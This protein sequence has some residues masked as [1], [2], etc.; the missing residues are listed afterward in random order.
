VVDHEPAIRA[1]SARILIR[2]G[3]RVLLASDGAEAL[4]LIDRQG[5]PRLMLTGPV[6]GDITGAE[7]AR[8]VSADW[9]AVP[10]LLMSGAST[11]E[12]GGPA[13]S[14]PAS[15]HVQN[16]FPPELLVARVSEAIAAVERSE[17]QK[18]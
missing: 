6:M 8:R 3:F 15:D 18:A 10:I 17:W 5:P 13:A 11:E 7:L 16:P 1:L 9:P 2:G 12:L 4:E 14:G